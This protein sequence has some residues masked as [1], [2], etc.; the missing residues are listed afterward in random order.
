[1]KN[2]Y[3]EIDFSKINVKCFAKRTRQQ[4]KELKQALKNLNGLINQDFGLLV[5]IDNGSV[6][7]LGNPSKYA[8]KLHEAQK[9]SKEILKRVL[10]KHY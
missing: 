1:M 9:E 7:F 2:D 6:S 8:K 5:N 4:I 10:K 3:K